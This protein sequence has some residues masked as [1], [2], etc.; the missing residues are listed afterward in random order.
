MT[1]AWRRAAAITLALTVAAGAAACSDGGGDDDGAGTT[2]STTAAPDPTTT[3]PPD[4]ATTTTEAAVVGTLDQVGLAVEEIADLDEP[5][6]LAARPSTDDLY[7]AEKDGRVRHV[8]VTITGT[9]TKAKKQYQLQTTPL[10]DLSREIV[11]GSEQGL[12]G[13]AFSSDGRRL[14]LDITAA[15]DGRTV[16]LEYAVDDRGQITRDSRRLLLEVPQP[17]ANHNGGNLVLGPDG[18]LYIGLGDGG[19]RGDPKG[20]GQDAEALLGSILRIDPLGADFEDA[21]A[22]PA[23]NPFANGRGGA[24]EV[25]LYGVRNPWRFSFDRATGDLWVADVGQNRWEE[26]TV[27]PAVGGFDAGRGANLGWDRME[28]SHEFEGPN[29][30]GGVLPI[31]EYSHDSG[32]CSITGG[33][34]YRG[35]DIPALVG[36]YLFAD[37]C[38]PGLNA[39]QVHEGRVIDERTWDDLGADGVISFGEDSDGE[40]FL[41]LQGGPVLKLRP[42]G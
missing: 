3:A 18:Y 35:K 32:G 27:L 36:S 11:T 40:L 33:F 9:G 5:I 17:Y 8:K 2:T 20:N 7:I 22:V 13:M 25:W 21:Y 29:P 31:H 28:G 38:R 15:P 14:Y 4:G 10:L 19:D 34:V 24:P 37:Y 26:I 23:G 42:A 6:A 30:S 12:L 16:V 41:L 1:A 39:I